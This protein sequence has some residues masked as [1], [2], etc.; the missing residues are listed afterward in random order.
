MYQ[1]HKKYLYLTYKQVKDQ[2]SNPVSGVLLSL[3][4]SGNYRNN[5]LT[6][7][8]GAYSFNSLNPGSYYLRPLLK[9]YVFEPSSKSIEVAEGQD[10]TVTIKATRVAFS[11]FGNVTSLNGDAEKFVTVEAVGENVMFIILRNVLN[12]FQGEYEETQTDVNGQFRIR[13]LLPNKSYKIG[14]KQQGDSDRIER[15]SPSSIS[16]KVSKQDIQNIEFIAF[17]RSNK[18]DLAGI[19]ET[20]SKWISSLT[21]SNFGYAIIHT[22]QVTLLKE[23]TKEIVKSISL[24]PSNYFDFKGIG[25]GQYILRVQSNLAPQ[26]YK[27]SNQEITVGVQGNV[28]FVRVPFQAALYSESQEVASAPV[29][30]LLF[31]MGIFASIFYYRTVRFTHLMNS[32]LTLPQIIDTIQSFSNPAV[33]KKEKKADKVNVNDA[34]EWLPGHLRKKVKAQRT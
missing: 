30:A 21:V 2:D 19:V 8:S 3:S 7:A 24:G 25:K 18:Y 14:I 28:N 32:F 13:G 34:D 16:V 11:C 27:F 31:G 4:G 22:I 10:L 6:T 1:T 5:N 17:R 23:D 26:V 20:E 33:K 9:E 29:F 12:Y 15:A